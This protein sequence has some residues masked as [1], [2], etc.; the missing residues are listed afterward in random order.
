ML[1]ALYKNAKAVKKST[2]SDATKRKSLQPCREMF[3]GVVKPL[4]GAAKKRPTLKRPIYVKHDVK[5]SS[6][7]NKF[8]GNK[9]T[10]TPA[11][12]SLIMN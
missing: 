4:N 5:R 3:A 8:F 11:S 6:R 2:A 10:Q 7:T 9:I 1:Y 12:V